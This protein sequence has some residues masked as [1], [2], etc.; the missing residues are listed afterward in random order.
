MWTVTAMYSGLSQLQYCS[1]VSLMWFVCP[2][3]LGCCHLV[4]GNSLIVSVVGLF[5]FGMA[6]ALEW[7]VVLNRDYFILFVCLSWGRVSCSLNHYTIEDKLELLILLFAPS[8]VGIIGMCLYLVYA[9]QE[10]EPRA[11]CV[12]G[13]HSSNWPISKVFEYF[14]KHLLGLWNLFSLLCVFLI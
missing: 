3:K 5:K 6:F 4:V 11:S 8:D 2:N 7:L 13:H 1:P 10:T 12:L 9:L 14:D